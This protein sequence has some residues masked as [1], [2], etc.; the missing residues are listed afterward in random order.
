MQSK[1][2]RRVVTR[3]LESGSVRDAAS[4]AVI[5]DDSQFMRSVTVD[6]VLSELPLEGGFR[7]LV[8]QHMPEG[9]TMSSAAD[10]IDDA[11]VGVVLTG[12]A[13]D[14]AAGIEAIKAVGGATLSQ[15][16][17]TSAVFGMP[18]RA[19]GPGSGRGDRGD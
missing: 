17:K 2:D 18:K 13:E 5:A 16:E 9:V 19:I 14:G 7:V 11:L 15:D 10:V 6:R 12:I 3:S 4:Q 1:R 8:V